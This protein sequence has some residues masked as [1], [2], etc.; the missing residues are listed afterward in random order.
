MAEVFEMHD[1]EAF[2]IFVYYCGIEQDD[3]LKT[4]IRESVEHWM[5]VRGWKDEAVAARIAADRIDILV[6]LNAHT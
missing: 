4:R 2:E 3:A 5:D 6:D 1:R